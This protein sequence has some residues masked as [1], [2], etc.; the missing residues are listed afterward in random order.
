MSP[1]GGSIGNW[2]DVRF[3]TGNTNCDDELESV[4]GVGELGC[5]NLPHPPPPEGCAPLYDLGNR[6]TGLGVSKSVILK[7]QNTNQ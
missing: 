1:G 6:I 7:P 3:Q 2:H 4:R 5:G